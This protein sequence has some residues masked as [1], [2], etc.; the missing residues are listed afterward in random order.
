MKLVHKVEIVGSLISNLL[1]K[2]FIP[3]L[4]SLFNTCI[5]SN[6]SLGYLTPYLSDKLINGYSLFL[7]LNLA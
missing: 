3:C 4:N 2:E 6:A 7:N 5:F 1:L